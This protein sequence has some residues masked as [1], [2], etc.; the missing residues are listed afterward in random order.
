M[1]YQLKPGTKTSYYFK[2]GDSGILP[3]RICITP[4]EFAPIKG[5]PKQKAGQMKATFKRYEE[6]VYK[7]GKGTIHSTIFAPI[8]HAPAIIG[9]GDL[10]GTQDLLVFEAAD[11]WR[12]IIVHLY[13]KGLLNIQ[14]I[15]NDLLKKPRP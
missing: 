10:Q 9:T 8:Q 2:K 11:G 12:E 4:S 5:K 7:N 15:I 6:S 1:T 3:T 13:V 14:H